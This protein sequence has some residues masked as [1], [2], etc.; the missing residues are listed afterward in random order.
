MKTNLLREWAEN[1]I[2]ELIDAR[3]D[4]TRSDLQ[5]VVA[6]LVMKLIPEDKTFEQRL[7]AFKVERRRLNA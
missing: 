4:M 3:D 7:E 6:A 2:L 5:G 1:E